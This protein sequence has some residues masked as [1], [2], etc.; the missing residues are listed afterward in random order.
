MAKS[1]RPKLAKSKKSDLPRA[2]FAK[3]NSEI[4]FLTLKA[5]KAFINLQKAFTKAPIFKRFDPEYHIRIETNA[6]GYA[7]SG[8]LS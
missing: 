4:N 6:L 1:K 7:I 8:V 5:K 2:N 3:V